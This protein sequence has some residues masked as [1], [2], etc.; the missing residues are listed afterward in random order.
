M[1]N[2]KNFKFLQIGLGSMG[3]RRI[4]NLLYHG[5]KRK[6]ISGFDPREDRC[7]EA[8][9]KYSIKAFSSFKE[10]L[11]K[12]DA[13]AYIISSPPDT[14]WPYFLHAARS[15]K[16]LFVEHPTTDR[17]YKELLRLMDG[18][19][20]AVPSCTLRFHPAVKIIKK[21]IDKK[22]I[23]E[24]ISFQYH[25]GQYLPLWHPWED[26]R[27]V[28]FSKKKTGACREMFAF[29]LG[30]LSHAL[31]LREISKILGLTEKLSDLDMSADDAYLAILKFKDGT[32][33]NMTIELLSK[34]PFRT[35][36]VIGSSG[37]LQWEWQDNEIKIFNAKSDNW[38][39]IKL[40]K[41][42]SEKN[43]VTTEDM[44]E[45]EIERFLCA[46]EKK[47]AYPFT[48]EENQRYLKVGFALEKSART[49]RQCLLNKI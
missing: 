25:L 28:Y 46:I 40:E 4:R 44:Y 47:C 32:V 24:V 35:L 23:G 20:V 13:D 39:I 26:F 1:Q 5:I 41:G 36:R 38:K 17:G 34:K 8:N 27:K 18:S 37:V 45:E 14:H 42:K 30:W 3:K 7:L 2:L 16:H 12:I 48:F 19:F 29:E 9:K 22:Q 15:K 31:N 10:A 49:Q 21:I 43:Y 11:K 33:G 6:N